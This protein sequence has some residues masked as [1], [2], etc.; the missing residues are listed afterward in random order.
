M[1]YP[2]TVLRLPF[3]VYREWVLCLRNRLSAEAEWRTLFSNGKRKTI[4]PNL[5]NSMLEKS[6][7]ASFKTVYLQSVGKN[8]NKGRLGFVKILLFCTATNPTTKA[9]ET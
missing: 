3:C 1:V 5:T 8:Q 4:N 2:F 7:T 9:I 6:K